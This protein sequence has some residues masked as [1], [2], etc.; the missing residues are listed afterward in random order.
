MA[1]TSP[2]TAAQGSDRKA[3]QQWL[4]RVPV[5]IDEAVMSEPLVADHLLHME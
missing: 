2:D 3:C 4:S 1:S 5:V